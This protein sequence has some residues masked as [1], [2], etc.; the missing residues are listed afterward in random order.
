MG[1]TIRIH[2]DTGGGTGGA[3]DS[4]NGRIGFV[5]SQSGDYTTA[6]VMQ[7]PDKNYVTDAE[8]LAIANTSGTNTGD[9]TPLS[10]KTKYESNA[11]TNAFTDAE[12]TKVTNLSGVNSGDE[13]TLSIQAK[14]PLKTVEGQSLEGSGDVSLN[15]GVESFNGRTGSV[16]SVNGDYTTA[17]V[18]E[19]T[20]K[21]YVTDA[22]STIIGNT[23]GTNSGDETTVSIQ[24]KRPLKTVNGNSLEGSG[25]VAISGFDPAAEGVLTDYES[26]QDTTVS[27]TSSTAGVT[28]L[29]LN[30]SGA[31]IGGTY[32]FNVSVAISHN[33]TNSNA[34]ID[35]KDFGVS[36]LS[37]IYTVEPKDNSNR[38][39]VNLSGE[40]SPN[41]LGAGQFQIQLDYGTDDPSDTT[42]VYFGY[43]SLQKVN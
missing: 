9:E 43:L 13:T 12:K 21:N 33:A 18:T 6:Q 25:D 37:Q 24:T 7:T 42:T 8:K 5:V 38:V 17:Q 39:W 34:F 14:R 23:S 32:K 36:V 35:I 16:V 11:N 41:P 15:I 31:T 10:V 27:S 26:S 29:N 4:F 40:V 1:V 28:Y 20:D 3:V 22:E 30:T 19:S 2:Q